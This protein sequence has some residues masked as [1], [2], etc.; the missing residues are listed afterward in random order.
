MLKPSGVSPG[1]LTPF[2]DNYELDEDKLREHLREMSEGTQNFHGPSIISEFPSLTFEEWKRWVDIM[3]EVGKEKHIPTWAFLGSESYEKSIRCARY[4]VEKGSDGIVLLAPYYHRYSQ[5]A[6]YEYLREF[7]TEFPNTPFIIYTSLQTGNIFQPKTIAKLSSVSDNMVGFK[8]TIGLSLHHIIDLARML[9][10][11]KV[12]FV[13]GCALAPFP[14]KSIGLGCT[15]SSESNHAH[16]EVMQLWNALEKGDMKEAEKMQ[17][18]LSHIDEIL[19]DPDTHFYNLPARNKAAM[20]I[21]GK[22]LGPV[23]RPVRMITPAQKVD[24]RAQLKEAGLLAKYNL[25]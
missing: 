22:S 23:R 10:R 11:E 17:N 25:T 19:L 12:V 7:M 9:D 8:I 13:G 20:E 24:L 21:I 3:I 16:K 14:L 1:V 15:Y 4:A 2:K 6:G 18:W 5:E